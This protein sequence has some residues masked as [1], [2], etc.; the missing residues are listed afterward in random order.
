MFI[1]EHGGKLRP[2]E[3]YQTRHVTPGKYC[4][5]RADRAI[6]LIVVKIIQAPGKDILC[7]LPKKATQKGARK[8]ISQGDLRAGHEAIDENEKGNRDQVANCCKHYLPKSTTNRNQQW[9]TLYLSGRKSA[10]HFSEPN[11]KRCDQNRKRQEYSHQT[12]H[13]NSQC[14]TVQE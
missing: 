2:E 14:S 1:V 4:Y 3:K 9:I 12:D 10:R 11:D 13:A 7:Q 6:N 8:S 5:H